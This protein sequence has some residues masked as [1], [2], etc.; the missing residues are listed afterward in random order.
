MGLGRLPESS[1]EPRCHEVYGSSARLA[2][3]RYFVVAH[4]D[5]FI[6]VL[7]KYFCIS[8]LV[9]DRSRRSSSLISGFARHKSNCGNGSSSEIFPSQLETHRLREE[10]DD[11]HSILDQTS[12]GDS[13][14]FFHPEESH[15]DGG[16]RVVPV[17]I[18]DVF[19]ALFRSDKPVFS[20]LLTGNNQVSFCCPCR[21]A[22]H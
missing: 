6:Y 22:C 16:N 8:R 9:P 20:Q 2:F 10:D 1:A 3:S 19:S 15:E 13:G 5:G 7:D 17:R 12:G 14:S 18:A 21:N 11:R 4:V